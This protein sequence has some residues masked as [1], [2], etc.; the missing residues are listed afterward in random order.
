M[1]VLVCVCVC[2]CVWVCGCV[3]VGGCGVGGCGCAYVGGVGLH[4]WECGCACVDV[5]NHR[6]CT[7]NHRAHTVFTCIPMFL[8]PRQQKEESSNHEHVLC[9]VN[10]TLEETVSK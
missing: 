7:F 6:C 10:S 3:G 1:G 4:M 8:R 9:A 2:V 5:Y